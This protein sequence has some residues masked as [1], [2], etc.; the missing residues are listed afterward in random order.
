MPTPISGLTA[1]Q[2]VVPVVPNGTKVIS[3]D[4]T[5]LPYTVLADSNTSRLE[6]SVD[7]TLVINSSSVATTIAGVTY[8]QFTGTLALPTGLVQSVIQMTGRNYVPGAAWVASTLY[9]VGT[10]II[11]LSGYVQVVTVGGTSAGSIPTFNAT[12]NGTT[13]DAGVTWTNLGV[14]QIT[15]TVKFTLLYYV[16]ENALVIAPPSGARSYK[17]QN[18]CRLEWVQPEYAGTI[19]VRVQLSTDPAGINPAFSQYQDLINNISRSE[20][21]VVSTS[22]AIAFDSDA[23][24]NTTTTIDNIEVVNFSS[25]DIPQS[26]VNADVFYAMVSTVVQEPNTNAIFESQQNGPITCGYVNL[27]TVNPTD[28]LALQ[29]KEDV[30]GRLIQYM[31]KYYPDL[32]LTPRSEARDLL[33]DPVAIELANMSVRSWFSRVATSVSAMN[34]IDDSNADGFSDDFTESPVKQQIARA[35]GLNANDTQTLIDRQFDLIG[36]TTGLERQ[37]ATSSVVTLTFYTY[38]K[39]T[40]SVTIPLGALVSTVPDSS[41]AAVTF[42][43][44]SSATLN[45]QSVST[46]YDPVNGW[47]SLD[48]AAE[49]QSTG[50]ITAVGAG[51]IRSVSSGIPGGWNC[52]NLKAAQNGSDVELNSKYAARIRDRKVTGIDS[53]SR[54]GLRT[55]ALQTPGVTG[56]TIVAAGDDDML[57]DWDP[58]RQKHVFGAVDIYT[59]GISVSEQDEK[60]AFQYENTG[61]Y[62]QPNTYL[63]LQLVDKNLLKFQ[64]PNFSSLGVGL[65]AGVELLVSRS[66]GSFY[67]ETTNAQFDNVN[68]FVVL[69]ANDMAYQY[70][71]D[72]I[73]KVRVPLVLNGSNANNLTTLT[74]L[75]TQQLTTS[76]QLF[77][78][79]Q[80]PFSHIPELQPVLGINSVIGATTGSVDLSLCSLIH[81]SDFLLFGGSNKANDIVNVST[82]GS[83]ATTAT[84][85]ALTAN[86]VLIDTS[87]DVPVN[88]NGVPQNILSVRNTTLDRVYTYG[89]DY[90]IVSLANYKTYG[91]KVLSTST[92]I[93]SVSI[94]TNVLTVVTNHNFS[95]GAPITLTNMGVAT[96]LNGQVVTIATATPTQFT[97]VYT[98]ANLATTAETGTATGSAIQNN[99]SLIVGYNKL[100]VAEKLTL[101]TDEQVVLTST[102]PSSLANQGFVSN[103]WLPESYG[104]TTLTL[105]GVAYNSDG[106]INPGTS[107]GLVGALVPR[108]SRYIKVVSNGIVMR[109]GTDFSL[110]VDAVSGTAALSR[111]VTGRIPSGG[112]VFVSYFTNEVFTFATQYPPHVE[113]LS[114]AIAD[115]KA[116]G[117]D[118]IVKAMLP[119]AVDVNMTVVLDPNAAPETMDSRIRTAITRV[120]DN[121]QGTLYQSELIRQVKALNGV[122]NVEVPLVKCAKSDG[123]YNVGVVVP[124]QTPWTVLSLDPAFSNLLNPLNSYITTFPVL[125]DSTIPSGGTPDSLVGL[126]YQGEVYRR[127]L[128]IQDFL[129]NSGD[130]PSFYIIG[131]NDHINANT[132]LSNSYAQRVLITIP[133]T[134]ANPAVRSYFVTYQVFNESGTKDITVSSTEYLTAGHITVNYVGA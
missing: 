5:V 1:L 69:D 86:P 95:P 41:T 57:R 65:M 132:P 29:R 49:S 9:V 12:L 118:I 28:F 82:T 73:S 68:G 74:Y 119:N 19:G 108:T 76:Y 34:Q 38:V 32:D 24:T 54:N 123:S 26:D 84:I 124:T 62:G 122:Q 17:A 59:R 94:T 51:T 66:T 46:Y 2:L 105:D 42:I 72:A 121:A 39:P 113:I 70:V 7:N 4:S 40:Q 78:R 56:V 104:N 33:I 67:L 127:A 92:P 35:Y 15:P 100:A 103:T 25:I 131:E 129:T 21:T 3:V 71:G 91:L 16:S 116:A 23:S 85:T 22:T 47:W 106:T 10:R 61:N 87:M 58:I 27:K 80:S 130:T 8:N 6:I 109:E 31:N 63:T 97:A 75:S 60:V 11:D 98:H 112:I 18:V 88:A 99:Q 90:S 93:T 50:S 64:I 48:V 126:L 133:A 37:G 30:A 101:I 43:T 20:N 134:V 107:T 125:P 115:T 44:R 79:L 13:I 111:I 52:T 117:A 81:T 55:L 102:L 89:V 36:E 83:T 96:F 114:N 77:A 110:T 53:S 14:T 120:L 128:S 45:P